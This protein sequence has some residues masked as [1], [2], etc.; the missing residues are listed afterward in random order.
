MAP[1][2]TELTV[3]DIPDYTNKLVLATAAQDLGL[4]NGVHVNTTP[5]PHKHTQ[6]VQGTRTKQSLP[7]TSPIS[8]QEY[9][10]QVEEYAK[11]HIT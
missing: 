5:V 6:P 3:G 2:N 8:P 10:K 1:S 11:S 4:N 9:H 7:E